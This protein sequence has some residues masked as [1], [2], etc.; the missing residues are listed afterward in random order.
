M[1]IRILQFL[2]FFKYFLQIEKIV[3]VIMMNSKDDSWFNLRNRMFK[4]KKILKYCLSLMI[5]KC[6]KISEYD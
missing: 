5:V 1:T 6:R 3:E 2:V 4:L